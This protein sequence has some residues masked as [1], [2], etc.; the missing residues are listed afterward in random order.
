MSRWRSDYRRK[1]AVRFGIYQRF[2]KILEINDI[3][4]NGC[5]LF[6]LGG[7]LA[8]MQ[9]LLSLNVI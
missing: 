9:I 4:Y 2:V 5:I 7:D 8:G 3:L 6:S 1:E